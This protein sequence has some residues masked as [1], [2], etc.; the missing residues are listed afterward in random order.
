VGLASGF[1][2]P[3]ESTSI[4][5]IQA[6]VTDLVKLMPRPGSAGTDPR[7]AAE[8]NRLN[9]MQYERIR[10]FL[11]LHYT[12][13]RRLGEPLWD[14]VRSMPLPDSLVHK[15]ELF[16]S[17]AAVPNYQYGLFARDSWLSVLIGQGITPDAYDRL[18]DAFPLT[19][20][21]ERLSEFRN[22][23]QTNVDA[24]SSHGA[25][26][27]NYAQAAEAAAAEEAAA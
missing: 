11:I 27:A 12:A 6:A 3:L 23:I 2:E 25:F 15:L 16:R 9:D 24:M 19:T 17:R 18:A 10:D 14:Y 7:L 21:E 22:R 4:Y 26:I 20:I 5:L 1:L 8:F 13:N